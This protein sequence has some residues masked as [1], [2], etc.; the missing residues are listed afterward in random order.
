MKYRYPMMYAPDMT[1]ETEPP[2]DSES[3]VYAKWEKAFSTGVGREREREIRY[4][5]G[6]LG[7]EI[8]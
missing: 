7:E 6:G 5:M 1:L 2:R 8:W 4:D 3:A